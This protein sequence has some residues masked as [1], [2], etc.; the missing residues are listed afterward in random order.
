MQ[1]NPYLRGA[2][3]G[4]ELGL[5]LRPET[6][7]TKIFINPFIFENVNIKNMAKQVCDISGSSGMSRGQ[8]TEHLRD[9]KVTD[10]DAKKYGYYDPTRMGLNFEVTKGGVV[11]PVNKGYPIDKRFKDICEARGIKIPVPIKLKDGT[12]KERTTVA[13]IILGG[14]RERMLQLAF[15]EQQVDLGKGADNR[16]ITRQ[17]DIEK[18]AQ[19]QYRLMCKLYGEDNIV[20]FVVHLD[21]KNPHVHCTVIPEVDGKISYNKVFGGSKDVARHKFWSLHDAIAEVNKKWGLERGDSIQQTGA[22]H[23]TSEEYLHELREEC[24]RMENNRSNLRDEISGMRESAHLLE[25]EIRKNE[26]KTKGLTTMVKNLSSTLESMEKEKQNLEDN[27]LSQEY[28]KQNLENQMKNLNSLMQSTQESLGRKRRDLEETKEL[29]EILKKQH[30]EKLQQVRE[31]DEKLEKLTRD[32]NRL[33]EQDLVNKELDIKS[34]GFDYL[35]DIFKKFFWKDMNQLRDRLPLEDRKLF[36]SIFDKTFIP[37]LAENGDEIVKTALAMFLGNEGDV[38][39]ISSG[40]GG[41][42]PGKGWRKRDDEDDNAY[43]YRCLGM[44][45]MMMRSRSKRVRR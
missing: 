38:I 43:R 33:N 29:L 25:K 17:P 12:E 18:W 1:Q 28:D 5:G 7:G 21:E 45:C 34:D 6:P 3:S 35:L 32:Y 42:G 30:A 13:N 2:S 8:S 22:K 41:G 31:M 11:A 14:S 36:D 15:G 44:A 27:I 23:R 10:P 20:A 9:Y 40:G 4:F 16:H 26:I 37:E 24:N 39:Q 19:D